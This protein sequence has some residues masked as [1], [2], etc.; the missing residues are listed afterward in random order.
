MGI[1]QGRVGSRST[2]LIPFL[3][4]SREEEREVSHFLPCGQHPCPAPCGWDTTT[5]A[6]Q[7]QQHGA[8]G[9]WHRDGLAQQHPGSLCLHHRYVTSPG[10][11]QAFYRP[12]FHSHLGLNLPLCVFHSSLSE[13]SL[14]KPD[15]GSSS[16]QCVTELVV[17][18]FPLGLLSS[19]V[20]YYVISHVVLFLVLHLP[21]DQSLAHYG[22]KFVVL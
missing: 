1:R 8:R 11:L 12:S 2:F 20:K 18:C 10:I 15:R 14:E 16:R 9:C 17:H 6:Q 21:G 7:Q 19:G 4:Q 5:S 22:G 13:F 3:C